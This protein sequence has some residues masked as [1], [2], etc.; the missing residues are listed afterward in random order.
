MKNL[1]MPLL[2]IV[3]TLLLNACSKNE[4]APDRTKLLTQKKW[5]FSSVSGFDPISAGLLELLLEGSSYKFNT[6]KT[7]EVS[8]FG[9]TY[10]TDW[11]FN[12]DETKIIM[13]PGTA[14]ETQLTIVT[15]NE[16]TLVLND[17]SDG[18]DDGKYTYKN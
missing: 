9:L 12:N 16:T 17:E 4:V 18:T 14:D 2:L 6:D 11:A 10:S 5:T 8:V 7:V 13:D 1:R 15:I 3:L